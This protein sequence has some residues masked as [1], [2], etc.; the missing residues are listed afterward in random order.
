MGG[1]TCAALIH[2][3]NGYT[4]PISIFVVGISRLIRTP[5]SNVVDLKTQ[6][7]LDDI[8]GTQLRNA[9]L[10]ALFL[11]LLERIRKYRA[12]DLVEIEKDVQ[13]YRHA[14]VTAFNPS[15]LK[16]VETV[17]IYPTLSTNQ[18]SFRHVEF[19]AEFVSVQ[20]ECIFIHHPSDFRQTSRSVSLGLKGG[21]NC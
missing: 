4:S 5:K 13:R 18:I 10:S 7:E 1:D 14:H 11:K 12:I 9:V 8:I 21:D 19:R 15:L 2:A 6:I 16:N 20:D 17:Q 3:A